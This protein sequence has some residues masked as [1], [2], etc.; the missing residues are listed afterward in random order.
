MF[1][2]KDE[3]CSKVNDRKVELK[4]LGGKAVKRKDY[5][6]ASRI[7]SEVYA[8]ILFY[9]NVV[10]GAIVCIIVFSLPCANKEQNTF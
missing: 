2:I 4:S 10:F 8:C 1:Q 7:Y 5:L 3:P 6:G 9:F